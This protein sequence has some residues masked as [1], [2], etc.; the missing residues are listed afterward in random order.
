M[1]LFV[2]QETMKIGAILSLM[3]LLTACGQKAVAPGN[4]NTMN[5]DAGGL[6]LAG[7]GEQEVG[8]GSFGIQGD[9]I[10]GFSLGLNIERGGQVYELS[11]ALMPL[12]MQAGTY[13]FPALAEPGMT[14]ASYKI[15]TAARDPIRDYNGGT[16]S[17]Q[18]SPVENDPESKLKI[19]ID[20][21]AVSDAPLPGFKRV[22]AVGSFDFNAAAL[23][24]AEPSG[25][26][27]SNGV[28]RSLAS[29]KAGKRL[30]PAFDAEVCG[31]EKKLVHCDFDVVADL[32]KPQ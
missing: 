7:A 18:F 10:T 25:A 6:R 12:P 15:K 20:K 13:H 19:Q 14:L 16:Y 23:P 27:V 31:A 17:Q 26:C 4:D 29:V 5:C 2:A 30:L 24:G 21:M 1:A 22:H 28:A 9:V 8:V 32:V 3:L 11:T